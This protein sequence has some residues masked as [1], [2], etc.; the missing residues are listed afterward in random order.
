MKS[1]DQ[2]KKEVAEYLELQEFGRN[3]L[4][5]SRLQSGVAMKGPHYIWMC[6]E[7][8]SDFICVI[9]NKSRNLT[10]LFIEV[11]AEDEPARPRKGAQTEFRD[12]YHL[13][14]QDIEY[15]VVNNVEELKNKIQGMILDRVADL[16]F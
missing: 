9:Q 12:H 14:H 16:Q 1:E 10:I 11:K 15:M 4:W 8:T 13:I 2:V 5:Q 7:G 6:K 3:I